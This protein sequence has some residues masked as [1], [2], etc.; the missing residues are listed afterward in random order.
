MA[1]PKNKSSRKDVDQMLKQ[2]ATWEPSKFISLVNTFL[3]ESKDKY[4]QGEELTGKSEIIMDTLVN[5]GGEI[6]AVEE[7]ET[8]WNFGGYL[9]VFDSHDIS[10]QRDKFTKST[11]FDIEDGDRISLYYNHGLDGTVKRAKIGTGH[12]SVKD[13]GIWLEGEVKKRT[14]YLAKHAEKIGQ[15]L[16]QKVAFKGQD[17][18]LFGLSSGALS[19]LVE[20]EAVQG[21]HEIKMWKIGEASITPTP[22]EPKTSC[23]SLKSYMEDEAEE[24]NEIKYHD[25]AT[26]SEVEQATKAILRERMPL[27]WHTGAVRTAVKG[28]TERMEDIVELQCVKSGRV[29]SIDNHATFTEWCDSLDSISKGM[30]EKLKMHDPESK[31]EEV[32]GVTPETMKAINAFIVR[33]AHTDYSKI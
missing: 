32:K 11:D 20:R 23:Y 4:K 26:Q 15:G 7:T 10:S 27:E 33:T 1:S 25:F 18:C 16:S 28:L 12:L 31:D 19:H 9:V 29:L 2:M 3:K 6:K 22:A 14:D 30:R 21:G 13:E 8:G 17:H 24:N 5:F